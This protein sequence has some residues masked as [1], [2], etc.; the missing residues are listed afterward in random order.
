M[1]KIKTQITG[2]NAGAEVMARIMRPQDIKL[3]PELST[4]FSID[5]NLVHSIAESMRE[6]G[7]DKSQ[8]LVIWKGQDCVVDG[9]TRL[10]SSLEAQLDEVF[11]VD[12]EF[13]TLED[14]IEYAYERQA[15]RRNLT[16]AEIY[17]AATRLNIKGH[18][19]GKGRSV[20]L[21]ADDLGVSPS[22]VKHARTVAA[23]GSE[24]DIAAVKKGD[25]SINK[26][27]QKVRQTD[28]NPDSLGDDGERTIDG[29]FAE[30]VCRL[31]ENGYVD[32]ASYLISY[33]ADIFSSGTKAKIDSCFRQYKKEDN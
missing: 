9:H 6:H 3:H 14:A 21:L 26:A 1:L 32:A 2:L 15:K 27:Y 10:K 13:D 4:I 16:Q 5:E 23:K 31:I 29:R 17:Q 7:F 28:K 22:T 18:H 30:A 11:V 12:R 8:P 24:E 25:M 20:E 33:C 19:D